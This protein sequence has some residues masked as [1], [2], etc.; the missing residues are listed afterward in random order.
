MEK[1]FFLTLGLTT[2]LLAGCSTTPPSTVD[3]GPIR[4]S[5]YS[6]IAGGVTSAAPEFA[7][8]RQ[9]VH[10]MIQDSITQNLSGRGLSKLPQDGD[11]IVAYLVIVGN[12]A[13]T[14]AIST[15]FG[16]GRDAAGLQ[17][18][19]HEAYT[20]SNN[21]N[22]FEAGTL[23]IDIIEAKTYKL[24]KRSFVVRPLLRNPTAEVQA[25][26]IQEAVDAA[27]QDLRLNR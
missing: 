16:Y 3:T 24:L 8:R 14:E 26:R 9:Q 2:L 7:D 23:L 17:E 25:H 22:R 15:Y 5:S 12:N 4:A 11:V 21:P 6:F 20:S 1:I 27:L 13:S 19:A 10:A 18:K